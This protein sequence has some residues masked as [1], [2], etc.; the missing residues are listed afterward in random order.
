V[1]TACGAALLRDPDRMVRA[2]RAALA[3]R[4]A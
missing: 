2:V 1:G 4:C 3:R